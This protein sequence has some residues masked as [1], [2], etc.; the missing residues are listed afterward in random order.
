MKNHIVLLCGIVLALDMARAETHAS[1]PPATQRL[2]LE[3]A[4]GLALQ[5]SPELR[6]ARLQTQAAEKAVAASGRW[7]N[8]ELKFEAEGVGGDLDGFNEAEYLIGVSQTFERSGKR[9]Y[10]RAVAQESIG[11]VFQAEAEKELALLA[12]VRRAFIEVMAQ[13][14]T[15]KV[16]EEQEELG[17][18]F[19]KVARTRLEAGGASQMELVQAELQLE[20]IILSQ[21]CCFGDLEA[22]RIRLASLIGIPEKELGELTGDYYTLDTFEPA[23]IA[24]SHP[25]LKRMDAR[26][27]ATRAQARL[28]KAKD[29]TD[30]TLGAGYKYEAAADINTFVL[31]AK[32]PLNFVRPGRAEEAATLLRADALH[33][34]RNDLSRSLQ[35]ELSVVAALYKGAKME[36]EMTRGKLLP[37]AEEAYE[38]SKAGYAAGRYSWVELIASQQHLA[39]IRVREIEALRDAHLARA[40]L[41]RFMKEG[42][43]R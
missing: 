16:R 42:L 2:T 3:Q 29:A 7:K 36:A 20:E 32:I 37:K 12:E 34:E 21:T 11:I 19:V 8:P 40:E 28:A 31:G 13:Q 14:E 18:A 1:S 23:A 9:K 10:D 22:A 6:A 5:N 24:E 33:A 15:G 17:R 38:L 39:E 35:R 4:L 30:I 41:Y 25:A 27:A 43:Q 26:I